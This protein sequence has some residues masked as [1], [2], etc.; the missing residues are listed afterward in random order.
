MPTCSSL[1]Y[2]LL[3]CVLGLSMLSCLLYSITAHK[4]T[5]SNAMLNNIPYRIALSTCIV[6]QI[7]FW[8]TCMYS[9]RWMD[10]ETSAWGLL[11]LGITVGGWIGLTSILE[12]DMHVAFVGIFIF[13][14]GLDLLIL[15]SLTWQKP[16]ADILVLSVAF[17][18]VCIVA[19]IILFNTNQFYIMEHVGFIA[20]SLIFTAFVLAHPPADWGAVAEEGG[21]RHVDWGEDWY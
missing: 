4:D 11:C 19:M 10:P 9:K 16:A 3:V 14:F 21:S 5:V 8:V 2:K 12:G 15:C 20:Y 7:C 18:L 17:L 1:L 6:L 13:F